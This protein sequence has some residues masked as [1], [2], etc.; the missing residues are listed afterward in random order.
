M[1]NEI[2]IP[3]KVR[4]IEWSKMKPQEE[5]R[6]EVSESE[7]EII[8][9]MEIRKV[10]IVESSKRTIQEE[11]REKVSISEDEISRKDRKTRS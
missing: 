11:P 1:N 3:R 4:T 7:D 2:K 6:E 8:K 5:S 9:P 10:K